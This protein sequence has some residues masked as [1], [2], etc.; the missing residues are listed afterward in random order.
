MNNEESYF[1]KTF[2]KAYKAFIALGVFSIFINTLMLVTPI[3]LLQLFDRVISSRSIETLTYLTLIAVFAIVIFGALFIIRSRI[4]VRISIWINYSLSPEALKRA[5]DELL[6][7]NTYATMVISDVEKVRG[8]L[9]SNHILSIFDAPWAPIYL[10][11][12][13]MLHPIVGTIATIGAV[14]L[15]LLTVIEDITTRN[16]LELNNAENQNN[17]KRVTSTLRN[18]ATIQAMGMLSAITNIWAKQ[19]T[20]SFSK[21]Q[22]ASNISSS[23]LGISKFCR[24]SLQIFVLG[25]SAYLVIDNQFTPGMMIAG[26]IILSKALAPVEQSIGTWNTFVAARQAYRRLE[27]FFNKK[28][29]RPVTTIQADVKGYLRLEGVSYKAPNVDKPI[30]VNCS[31]AVQPGQTLIIGGASAAGKTTLAKLLIG[32]LKP[33]TGT[34]RLDNSDIYNWDRDSFGQHIGYL[35]QNVELFAGSIKQ[36]IARMSENPDD[37]KVVKAAKIAGVHDLILRLP[38]GYDTVLDESNLQISIGQRQRLALAS[39]LYNDPQLVILD[40]PNSY[41]D[42]VG[43]QALIKA[44]LDIKERKGT[45]ILI[46]HDMNLFQL[47]D[48]ILLMQDGHVAVNGTKDDVLAKI[49]ERREQLLKQAKD[50]GL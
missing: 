16:L 15:F 26:S 18:A 50:N 40:E 27:V 3:Y 14:V 30:I 20:D 1:K 38:E 2:T 17:F 7:G 25:V 10:F 6:H 4:L 11:V 12:L 46:T 31:F 24:M 41:L 32:A 33:L 44:L 35:P 36:N 8:F 43:L 22:K 23:I 47:A 21:Q 5:P 19:N 13:F 28:A 48:N 42:T 45:L 29:I 9:S 34:V 37:E 39:A 49:K